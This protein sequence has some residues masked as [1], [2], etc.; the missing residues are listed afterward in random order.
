MGKVPSRGKAVSSYFPAFADGPS[1]AQ[2]FMSN[3]PASVVSGTIAN[4]GVVYAVAHG[5]G[6]VPRAILITPKGTVGQLKAITTSANS[7]GLSTASAATATN[8]YVAG[9]KNTSFVAFCLL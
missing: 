3:M 4:S 8:F 6:A 7:V 1:G 2:V 9:A 5:L